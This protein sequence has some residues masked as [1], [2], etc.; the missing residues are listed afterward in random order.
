LTADLV[1]AQSFRAAMA[2]FPSG[3][4]VATTLDAEGQPRGFT[5]SAFAAASLAPP[6]V[7]LCLGRTAECHEAFL[8]AERIA[9]SILRPGHEDVA[10]LFAT[11]GADK[12]GGEHVAVSARGLPAVLEAAAVLDC[13]I[14]DRVPAGDHTL[15]LAEVSSVG[16]RDEI[17]EPSPAI[18]HY[19]RRFWSVGD[20]GRP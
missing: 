17:A 13:R 14:T 15:L 10:R 19:A 6:M 20:D 5:A 18:V 1:D 7:L 11:R 8:S 12:F 2:R 4:I 3:V 9:V 16:L